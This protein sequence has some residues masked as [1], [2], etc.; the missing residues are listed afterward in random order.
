MFLKWIQTTRSRALNFIEFHS[1]GEG[2]KVT[3]S[4]VLITI[5]NVTW[6]LSI[7]Q[8]SMQV[9]PLHLGGT[10]DYKFDFSLD[11]RPNEQGYIYRMGDI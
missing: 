9:K 3:C 2:V 5:V 6:Q 8:I 10:I 1:D 4:D 11:A 7:D